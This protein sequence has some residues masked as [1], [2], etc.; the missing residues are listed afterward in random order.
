M[1]QLVYH[2]PVVRRIHPAVSAISYVERGARKNT[3]HASVNGP[4]AAPVRILFLCFTSSSARTDDNKKEEGRKE[5]REAH[6][7][8]SIRKHVNMYHTVCQLIILVRR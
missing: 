6:S 5:R 4:N 1:S 2:V 8:S 3:S 7:H